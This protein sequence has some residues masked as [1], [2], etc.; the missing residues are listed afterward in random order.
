M[1]PLLPATQSMHTEELLAPVTA[2][3]FPAQ[4]TDTASAHTFSG[5]YSF[6]LSVPLDPRF[7]DRY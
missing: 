3:Y 2:E 1:H 5:K 7:E 4:A 6:T